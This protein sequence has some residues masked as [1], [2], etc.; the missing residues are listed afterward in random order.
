MA[1]KKLF[2]PNPSGLIEHDH[3]ND[4]IDRHCRT[5]RDGR[6]IETHSG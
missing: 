3:N 6:R 2:D 4:G 1:K 5:T